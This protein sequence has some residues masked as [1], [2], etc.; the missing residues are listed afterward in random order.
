LG[1]LE[2]G[3]QT[4]LSGAPYPSAVRFYTKVA[5]PGA[6]EL[7][8]NRKGGSGFHDRHGLRRLL[9]KRRATL[10]SAGRVT[11]SS[12]GNQQMIVPGGN[13][14]RVPSSSQIGEWSGH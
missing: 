8:A 14:A 1:R 6:L 3:G 4:G 11:A 7:P 5:A 10:C 13:P 12:R 2:T 9:V